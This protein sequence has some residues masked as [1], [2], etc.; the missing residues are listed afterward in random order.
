MTENN[1]YLSMK[2]ININGFLDNGNTLVSLFVFSVI[3]GLFSIPLYN[4]VGEWSAYNNGLLFLGVS[5]CISAFSIWAVKA[6]R[7][8]KQILSLI[9]QDFQ[10]GDLLKI[11]SDVDSHSRSK[12]NWKSFHSAYKNKTMKDID[13]KEVPKLLTALT[14][15]TE[16]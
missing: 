6:N 3:I 15:L 11:T 13:S 16:K 2:E 14:K 8:I 12:I 1:F 9:E 5:G 10:H 7:K 4:Y